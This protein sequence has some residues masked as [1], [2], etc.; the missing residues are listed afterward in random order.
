MR[1]GPLEGRVW[2]DCG[3][4]LIVLHG[5]PAAAGSARDLA[6]GLADRFRVYEPWQRGAEATPLTVAR[7]SRT[8]TTSSRTWAGRRRSLGTR[9]ARCWRCATALPTP[10]QPCR[11]C[12]SVAAPSMSR[13]GSA[14]GSLRRSARLRRCGTAWR[15]WL[16]GSA[17]SPPRPRSTAGWPSPWI[18]SR[19]PSEPDPTRRIRCRGRMAD[20]GGRTCGRRRRPVPAAFARSGRRC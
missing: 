3:P 15:S 2:G 6:R 8:C 7:P 20:C 11:W 14:T 1:M 12:W 19:R 9:G 17:P 18:T 13:R 5:G 10:S 16:P 4:A